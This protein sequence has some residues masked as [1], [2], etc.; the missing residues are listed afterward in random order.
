MKRNNVKKSVLPKLKNILDLYVVYP[1]IQTCVFC[2]FWLV[3]TSNLAGGLEGLKVRLKVTVFTCIRKTG[4]VGL[5]SNYPFH[6]NTFVRLCAVRL[7]SD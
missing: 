3:Q 2:W 6:V 7:R 4:L 5:K 1:L